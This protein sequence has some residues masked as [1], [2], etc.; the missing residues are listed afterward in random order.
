[1]RSVIYHVCR[2][3]A[4]YRKLLAEID[5]HHAAG[6][7]SEYIRY[8]EARKLEYTIAKIKEAMRVHPSAALTF[9]RHVP[10]GGVVLGGHFIPEGVLSPSLCSQ[11]SC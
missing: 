8:R 2:N 9:P 10:K 5:L 11:K 4:V 7:F 1:M 3:P 6:N